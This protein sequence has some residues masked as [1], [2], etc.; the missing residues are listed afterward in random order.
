MCSWTA[1]G[2]YFGAQKKGNWQENWR[3]IRIKLMSVNAATD[4]ETDTDTETKTDGHSVNVPLGTNFSEI[5]IKMY[6]FLFKKMHLKMS[7][8]NSQSFCLGLNVLNWPTFLKWYAWFQ[9]RER[10]THLPLNKMAAFSQ[11]IFSDAFSWMK[12]FVFW[13]RFH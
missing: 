9:C 6:I 3:F 1:E 12:T 7:S 11:M 13:L 8:G 2:K 4:T 10:L 5:I